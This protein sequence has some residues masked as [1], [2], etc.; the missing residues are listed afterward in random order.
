LDYYN[1]L[2]GRYVL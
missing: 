1:Q 2:F